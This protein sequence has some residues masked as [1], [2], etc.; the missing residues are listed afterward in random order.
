ML[1]NRIGAILFFDAFIAKILKKMIPDGLNRYT[2]DS[3][4]TI[5]NGGKKRKDILRKNYF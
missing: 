3:P 4:I 2:L 5:G 1:I